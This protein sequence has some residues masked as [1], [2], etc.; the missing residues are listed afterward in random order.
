MYALLSRTLR[1]AALAAAFGCAVTAS[2]ES[3]NGSLYDRLGGGTGIAAISDDLVD[4]AATNPKT[5][6]SWH[7][8][9]LGRVKGVLAEYLCS[10][11]G[12][13]CTYHGDSLKEI[14]A[15]LDIDESEMYALVES[16]R[17]ILIR[18]DVP[19]RERNELL[20]LLAPAKRDVVTK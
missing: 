10:L 19:L 17:K 20:A 8:V 14:H 16:L 4:E 6:R 7:K 12:G 15:G 2:A 18:R 5:S 1:I 9:T 13:P 3:L 11:T